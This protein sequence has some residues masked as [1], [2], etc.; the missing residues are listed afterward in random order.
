MQNRMLD[1]ADVLIDRHPMIGV[2]WIGRRVFDPGIGEADEIPRRVDEGIHCVGLAPRRPGAFRTFYALPRGVPVERVP[3][4]VE[5]HVL[6]QRHRQIFFRYRYDAT[7]LAV[8]YRDRAAPV[9]LA[10][11]SPIAQTIVDLTLCDRPVAA[12]F[13]LQTPGDFL[14]CFFDGHSVEESRIDHPAFAV[15]G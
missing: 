12:C 15:V 3:R 6:R 10:R 7:L 11:N 14:L 9:A 8:D 2:L 1:A 13:L 4:L 5:S